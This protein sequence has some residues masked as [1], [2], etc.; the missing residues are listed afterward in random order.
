MMSTT[1]PDTDSTFGA[2]FQNSTTANYLITTDASVLSNATVTIT[3]SCTFSEKTG[4]DRGF[5]FEDYTQRVIVGSMF[6]LV[7]VFGLIGDIL[8]IWAVVLS[9]KL[10]TRTNAFVVNLATA[11][12]F[13][14]IS[15]PLTAVPLFSK[16]GLLLPEMVCSIAAVMYYSTM[17]CSIINLTAI[18]I[19]RFVLITKPRET[20]LSIY[21][22]KKIAAMLAFTWL[23]PAL[24]CCFPLFG[25]GRWGYSDKYKIC[26]L[27]YSYETSYIFQGL[28]SGLIYPIP[29]IILV[30][31]Y[32]KIYR[33]ITGHT[34]RMTGNGIELNILSPG[35]SAQQQHKTPRGSFSKKQLEITKNLFY[36]VCSF[37][38]CLAPFAISLLIPPLEFVIPWTGVI[39]VFNSAINPIIYGAKHPHFKEVFR[40]ML[41]CRY[42][43][44]P[45]PSSCLQKMISR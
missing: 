17:A 44:I 35:T 37:I 39:A 32:F 28:A 11:D 4:D 40:H 16:K 12:L 20:Y 9:K 43:I 15:G 31:C 3:Q 18:A 5:R 45:E 21:T 34:K 19:N 33:Y 36:V 29:L 23:Y 42:H 25:L 13:S 8:V 26:A 38:A 1:V 24:V 2:Q 22:T 30:F 41:R 14:C 27:D 7:P 10:Q 6:C